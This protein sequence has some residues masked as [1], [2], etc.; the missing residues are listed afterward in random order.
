MIQKN[1]ILALAKWRME[2]SKNEFE[3]AKK[4]YSQ[5]EY[6]EVL[7]KA[8]Y[9]V[10]HAMQALNCFNI[11]FEKETHKSTGIHFRKDYIATGKVEKIASSYISYLQRMREKADYEDF[12]MVTDKIAQD[13]IIKAEYLT[14][15]L[16][17][18]Y[19]SKI[20]TFNLEN[21]KS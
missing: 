10:F 8:Y 7:V 9:A 14:K 5:K 15:S 2:K 19:L 1:D 4:L 20:Q 3:L 16:Y 21:T 17:E 18:M 12:Y 6:S 13:V 11:G